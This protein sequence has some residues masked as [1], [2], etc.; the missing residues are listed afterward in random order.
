L[1]KSKRQQYHQQIAQVLEAQFPETKETQPELVAHHYTEAGLAEQAIPCWQQAGER[2]TQRSANVEAIA[3]LSKGLALLN[4]LPETSERARQELPLQIALGVPLMVTKGYAAPELERAYTRAR[5][6]CQEVGELPQLFSILG[7]LWV[8]Y[9]HRPEYKMAHELAEH[10]LRE[11]QR[12]QDP[13]QLMWGHY[14]LG[15]TLRFLGQAALARVHLEKA[16]TLYDP[17]QHRA[18][19]FR[20]GGDPG[21]DSLTEL[22]L[23]LWALGYPGQALKKLHEALAIAREISHP[24]NSATALAYA[25][26]LHSLRRDGAATKEWAEATITLASDQRFPYW[27]AIGTILRGWA[28]VEQGQAEEGLAQLH[29]GLGAY[30]AISAWDRPHLLALLAAAYGKVGQPEEGVSTLAEALTLV[31]TTGEQFYEAE[32]Y[33]LKGE[34]LL[35][36][37]I[38]R[39][40]AKGKRQKSENPT[41]NSQILDPQSEAEACF[42]QAREIARRQQA[43]SLELRASTSLARLWQQQGKQAEARQMLAEIYDWFTEGFDTKDLQEAKALLDELG[44]GV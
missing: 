40:K 23:A 42:H 30:R 11:A 35:T 25:A 18:L 10:A 39:Q 20:A 5:E 6:L 38:K 15:E 37:E 22:A 13:S 32:L 21:T 19:A 33:R 36:Q 17:P 1:L 12:M 27:L 24:F 4:T 26:W 3:H 2:A 14:F 16:L 29:Q 43:K 31:N 41:A 7:G 44:E 8:F 34:L 9:E 28:L